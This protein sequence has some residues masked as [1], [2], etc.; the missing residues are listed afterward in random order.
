MIRVL[1]N[2]RAAAAS[3]DRLF[4]AASLST[5]LVSWQ[6]S[7]SF[8]SLQQRAEL[9]AS[10]RQFFAQRG[11][12][13]VETPLLSASTVTDPSVNSFSVAVE[14]APSRTRFL[15]TSPEYAMKRLLAAHEKP[16]F[17]ICKAFRAGEAGSRHNPEFTLLEWYRPDFDHHALMDEVEALLVA[18]LGELNVTRCSYQQLFLT[19]LNVDPFTATADNLEVIARQHLDAGD[20]R[21]GKDMW[22][23]LLMSHVVEPLLKEMPLVFVYD[24]PASQAALS[25]IV[26]V[27][28]QQVGQRFEAYLYG[29]ELANGYC[30]LRDSREQR[31]RFE[32]D[33]VKRSEQG[34]PRQPLDEHLLQALEHGLPACSGVALGIDRLLMAASGQNEMRSVLAFEWERA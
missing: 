18:C 11:V 23:D 13:E 20:M 2:T 24:Y 19:Q 31:S 21:G 6:P 12:V 9:L 7:A 33:N 16:I 28:G 14:N 15:Q 1:V 3:P 22:L 10:V 4:T 29:V 32:Q 30:E 17:Q 5:F 8:E 27:D 25:Q 34:M 26:E